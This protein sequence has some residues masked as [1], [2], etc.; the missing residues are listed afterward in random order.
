MIE[1]KEINHEHLSNLAR[2]QKAFIE[3]HYIYNE[4]Y[5]KLSPD[6]SEIFVDYVK[7]NM[8]NNKDKIVFVAEDTQTKTI[9]GYISGW[10][11]Q[12]SPFYLNKEYGYLS[13]I[14]VNSTHRGQGISKMLINRLLDWFKQRNTKHIELSVD[15]KN[16]TAINAFEKHGFKEFLKRMRLS[17][18]SQQ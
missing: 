13:N 1:I 8:I 7:K 5:Y 4:E 16:P 9:V 11:E 6:A 10:V 2:L 3:E 14:Y 15:T 12:K 18:D 17:L